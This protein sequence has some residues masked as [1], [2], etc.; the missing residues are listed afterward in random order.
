MSSVAFGAPKPGRGGEDPGGLGRG[1]PQ[2]SGFE[3]QLR[4]ASGGRYAPTQHAAGPL[5]EHC[6][7]FIFGY[8]DICICRCG[9]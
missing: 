8:T 1:H 9:F 4:P 7:S 3:L 2:G 6:F 5:E